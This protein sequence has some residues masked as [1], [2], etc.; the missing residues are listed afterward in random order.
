MWNASVYFSIQYYP[1]ATCGGTHFACAAAAK[2]CHIVIVWNRL[3]IWLRNASGP[4][5]KVSTAT[6]TKAN[7]YT[8]QSSTD[9][10]SHKKKWHAQLRRCCKPLASLLCFS[11]GSRRCKSLNS[12]G[13]YPGIS[14]LNIVC[15]PLFHQYSNLLSGLNENQQKWTVLFYTQKIGASRS[16]VL[17]Y[18]LNVWRISRISKWPLFWCWEVLPSAPNIIKVGS[19]GSLACSNTEAPTKTI[20]APTWDRRNG[21]NVQKPTEKCPSCDWHWASQLHQRD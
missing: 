10:V 3:V 15:C 6:P 2:A 13:S 4:I 19:L 8:N 1:S 20:A 7:T 5:Q 17:L 11:L 21:T 16:Q 14:F 9:M 18:W 12:K